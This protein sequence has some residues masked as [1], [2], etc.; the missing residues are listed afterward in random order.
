MAKQH[1]LSYAE[2]VRRA[3]AKVKPPTLDELIKAGDEFIARMP[4][5]STKIARVAVPWSTRGPTGRRIRW[6][7][8]S[9][10]SA[11]GMRRLYGRSDVFGSWT[12]NME[13]WLAK[14]GRVFARFWSRSS[15]VDNLS[16][17]VLGLKVPPIAKGAHADGERWVPVC[18]RHEYEDWVTSEFRG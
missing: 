18:L 4:P 12:A 7:Y 15:D 1:G 6:Q 2:K 14:D 5:S 17:E 11:R 3:L 8:T 9:H 13:V 16:Y 10:F